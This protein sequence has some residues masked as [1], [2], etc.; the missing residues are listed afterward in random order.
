[1]FSRPNKP[2]N[3]APII[4]LS[5]ICLLTACGS[6]NFSDRDIDFVNVSDAY[7]LSKGDTGIFGLGNKTPVWLDPRNSDDFQAGHIPGALNLPLAEVKKDDPRLAKYNVFIV[8][9]DDYNSP[10]ARA[11]TKKLLAN[12]YTDIRTLRGGL[13]AWTNAGNETET[14]G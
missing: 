14:G 2:A 9:G 6:G 3:L 11:M 7:S 4:T 8:Y 12:E 13:R 1:M 5:C 10:I